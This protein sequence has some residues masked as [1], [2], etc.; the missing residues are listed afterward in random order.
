MTSTYRFRISVPRSVAVGDLTLDREEFYSWLWEE[1]QEDRGL[2]GV[3][4]GTLL[5]EEAHQQGLETE[6]FTVDSG[7][8]PRERDWI[9]GQEW[10]DV[11]V[12]FSAGDLAQRALVQLSHYPELKVAASVEEVLPQDWDAEWKASFRGIDLLPYWRVLPPWVEAAPSEKFLPR[13]LR[14]NPGAGFGTGTHE[15]TQLCLEALGE[16]ADRRGSSG[17]RGFRV[18]DFGSGSGILSIGAALTGAEVDA[19][20]IDPLANENAFENARMNA[21]EDRV[22]ITEALPEAARR[23]PVVVANILKPVLLEFADELCGRLDPKP[24]NGG[25]LLLSGLVEADVEPVT[26]AYTQ[27]LGGR[28]PEVRARGEWR[29]LFWR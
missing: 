2:V 13:V 8:A 1:F 20:E 5:S 10:A 26:E 7:Q 22:R 23:Y 4:E 18:F 16:L 21:V 6:S 9:G 29:M 27:R 14:L 28:K 15:T 19:C 25:A 12:Y 11:E 3:H 24:G 17:L